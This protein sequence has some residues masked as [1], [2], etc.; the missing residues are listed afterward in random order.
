[1]ASKQLRIAINK[2]LK[3]YPLS[4]VMEVVADAALSRSNAGKQSN[5]YPAHDER[6]LE[7]RSHREVELRDE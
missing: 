6:W 1:L 7:D 3:Y 2:L 4:D 5:E